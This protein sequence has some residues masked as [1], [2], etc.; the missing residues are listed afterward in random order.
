MREMGM[1]VALCMDLIWAM[2]GQRE[3]L[4]RKTS[5]MRS[6]VSYAQGGQVFSAIGFVG[7]QIPFGHGWRWGLNRFLWAAMVMLIRLLGL[8]R[9][10]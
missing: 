6:Q 8:V 1:G 2:R 10:K 5:S 9:M 4:R 7:E 3:N